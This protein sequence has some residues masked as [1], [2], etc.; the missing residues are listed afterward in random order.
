[1]YT[2]SATQHTH[3][4]PHKLSFGV[5]IIHGLAGSGVLITAAMAAMQSV[6]GSILFLTIFSV[7]C[8]AGMMSGRQNNWPSVLK[9]IKIVSQNATFIYC[10]LMY[11]LCSVMQ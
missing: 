9:K 4:H 5:G 8:I 1:M 7:G 11:Y 3:Q 2:Q 10:C 6:A